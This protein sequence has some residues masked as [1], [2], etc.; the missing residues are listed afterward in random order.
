MTTTPRN[1]PLVS[2]LAAAQLVVAAGLF[3][4][5][6][7]S[8]SEREIRRRQ[9]ALPRGEEALA[10]GRLAMKD[11]D[12]TLAHEEFRA[13]VTYLPDAAVSGKSHSEAVD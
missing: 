8:I 4:Q 13:A 10:R 7:Q 9:A 6:V 12:F 3:A 2:F 1:L 11:Q 5:D